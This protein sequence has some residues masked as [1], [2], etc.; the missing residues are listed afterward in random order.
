MK[1]VKLYL[2]YAGHCFAKEN[3]AIQGGRKQK[4]AFQA[5]WGL[6]EHPEKGWILYDTGYTERFFNAT[7][8]FPNKVYAMM[9]KVVINP[10]NEVKAQLER[11]NISAK[12]IK[13]VIITH[14]H[15]DHVAGMLDFPEATFYASRAAL[16]QTLKISKFIAFSKGI[17]KDLHPEDLERRTQVI[18][19]ICTLIPDDILGTKYDLFGDESLMVVPLPGHAAGQVGLLL[20]TATKPYFLI[21]D[22]CWLKKS[23]EDLTLPN[24]IV[25]L[26][27]HS[28]S[29]FKKSLNTVHNY[30]KANPNATIVPT[31]C[32]ETTDTLVSNEINMD[33][34]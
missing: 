10:E 2:N 18:E 15:A 26:F 6:I 33:V 12:D 28:W 8:R 34:L 16:T 13:H 31:H 30:H 19:D 17:L 7:K 32:S 22:A 11:H 23:Y 4:I 21:A 20:E 3:D 27:F 25:K 9:T 1:K 5:L 29:D 24:P 14:F